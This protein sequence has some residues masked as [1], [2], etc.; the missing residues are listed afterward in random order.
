MSIALQLVR[1]F[2]I[3]YREYNF[4]GIFTADGRNHLKLQ[5]IL[6]K[7]KRYAGAKFN[8]LLF[9]RL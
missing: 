5:V 7:F 6:G 2:E 3:G 1:N 4:A 9:Q 8:Q